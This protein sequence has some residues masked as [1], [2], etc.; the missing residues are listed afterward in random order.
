MSSVYILEPPTSG[1]VLLK[2]TVGDIDVELWAKE[3]PK[4]C[5]NFIQLCL[6]GYYDN[7]IFH[8]VVKGFIAQGG[9]PNGDG[10]GGESI[11]GEPFK[12]EFHQRLR[13]TRRG[14][15]AMANGGKDDNGSQFFFT[16]G[17]TPEL[18]DKHTIFGKITG[19][20][21]FN[22]LKLEDGLIR[23]ERPIYPHKIIKTEVLNNP[24]ADIQPR[25]RQVEVK[26]KKKK[27]KKPGVKNFKL[28]S[29]GEEA[30]EDEEESTRVNE[31][32]V[33]KGK[34]THDVLDDP[35]L[36]SKTE[37]VDE[38]NDDVEEVNPEEQLESI[39]KK[40]KRE[41]KK[42]VPTST[43][44]AEPIDTYESFL[45]EE[46][47]EKKKKQFEE[48]Q[49]EIQN[50][51]KEYHKNKLKK[52]EEDIIAT[53]KKVQEDKTIQE[54]KDE[55]DKYKNKKDALPKKGAGREQFTL[56][57]LEKFKKKIQSMK[58][59]E[60]NEEDNEEEQAW[61][62]HRLCFQDKNPVLAKD[63]NRKDDDWFEIYDPR[64]ALNKRRRGETVEK[65][66]K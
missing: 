34:S 45:E 2:T 14:L 62:K 31:K 8:R 19:D 32:F 1:K 49:K 58:D 47:R 6:E 11:Y 54:Y 52:K 59:G 51:K 3:T 65:F 10:T 21:I 28:L 9:D 60:E 43:T 66:K 18:Q 53:E 61:L 17:A 27:E 50:V 25:L 37:D 15:L 24:F 48:I 46:R 41:H 39:R 64:N 29:F 12:D 16:L 13:F 5:R 40:L 30:E 26:E 42:P 38:E 7:T 23:D 44:T 36:S 33:G 4:T 22:M 55:F 63:A 20:T 56:N 35:K 57:L